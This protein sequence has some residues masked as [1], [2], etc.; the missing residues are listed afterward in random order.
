MSSTSLMQI[1][2]SD[3]ELKKEKNSAT[4]V[5][6]RIKML[7]VLTREMMGRE[8]KVYVLLALSQLDELSFYREERKRENK[9]VSLYWHQRSYIFLFFDLTPT[10]NL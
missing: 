10:F 5:V 9:K 2:I 3:K 8:K 4:E 1:R 7:L 6:V